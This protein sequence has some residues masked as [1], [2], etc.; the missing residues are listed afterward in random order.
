MSLR[1]DQFFYNALRANEDIIDEVDGRIFNPA[2]STVDENEDRV[3]YIVI[4]FDGL[5][6]DASTKDDVEGDTDTVNVGIL[7]VA[8]DR[9][10]LAELTE[11]VRTQCREYLA[12]VEDNPSATD[13]D[14]APYDWT[15]TADPVQYDELKPCVF[16]QLHYQ[17]ST[18]I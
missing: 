17:C 7:C 4:T 6:N 8:D 3:P 11:A 14:L 16:Q 10:A 1:T 12:S 13:Y 9:E 15:F 5:T 2:R 18:N